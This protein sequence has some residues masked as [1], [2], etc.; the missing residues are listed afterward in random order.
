MKIQK[1]LTQLCKPD[2]IGAPRGTEHLSWA[3]L[4]PE[5]CILAGR[6]MFSRTLVI[7]LLLPLA[8]LAQSAPP[9][10]KALRTRDSH[11]NLTII[12][13]PYLTPD[14][15]K[16]VFGKKTPIEAGILAIQVHFQN[17]NNLPIQINPRTVELIISQPGQERQHLGALSAEEVAN[18]SVLHTRVSG[19][20]PFPFPAPVSG[21]G[22]SKD[23][24]EMVDMLHSVALSTDVFPPHATTHGFIFFDM[25][26]D[27]EAIHDSRLYMPD[28]I[29]MT[30]KKALFFFE[31]DL[32]DAPLK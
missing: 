30:D 25:N 18:R 32:S 17:D 2:I 22:R 6:I 21:T 11:Q 27:F 26:H 31:I 3:N 10:P 19:R 7:T 4:Q 14:R 20:S 8:G 24:T 9:D 28:L 23:W 1:N 15:Y 12:A 5:R 29:F 16:S 13:D